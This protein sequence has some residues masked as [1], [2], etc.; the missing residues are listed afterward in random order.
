MCFI[1]LIDLDCDGVISEDDFAKATSQALGLDQQAARQV[2][3]GR[4]RRAVK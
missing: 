4:A 3:I 2:A 1:K